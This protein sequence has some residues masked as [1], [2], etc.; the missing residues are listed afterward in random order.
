MVKIIQ[1]KYL[2]PY[3]S[4]IRFPKK[5]RIPFLQCIKL[6]RPTKVNDALKQKVIALDKSGVSYN[7]I[8]KQ[9]KIGVTTA[10]KILKEE[11][12][13]LCKKIAEEFADTTL[14]YQH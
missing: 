10:C 9:L 13:K 4:P 11:D 7:K 5:F 12:S 3:S 1:K 2:F 6:G 8:A 14:N